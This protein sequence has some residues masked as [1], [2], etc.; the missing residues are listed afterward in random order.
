MGFDQLFGISEFGLNFER[1]RLEAAARNLAM[2]NTV[3]ADGA[4]V[5]PLRVSAMRRA[6]GSP[7]DSLINGEALPTV[8]ISEAPAGARIVHDPDSPLADAKGN[9]R[10]PDI[11]PVEQMTTLITAQR[12]YEANIRAINAM[13]SMILSAIGIGGQ[14]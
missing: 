13:R 1:L 3:M 5:R 6:E 10:Y 8:T 14:R 9:V 12:A 11:D 7:F 2:A 4:T